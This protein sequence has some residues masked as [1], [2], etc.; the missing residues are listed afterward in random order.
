MDIETLKKLHQ[1]KELG[2]IDE[3]EFDQQKQKIINPDVEQIKKQYSPISGGTI[4]CLI[5][6][7]IGTFGLPFLL[8]T[9]SGIHPF[10][11]L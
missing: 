1:L 10:I 11:I 2:I 4:G 5:L 3:K 8:F 9:P 7:A 6:V